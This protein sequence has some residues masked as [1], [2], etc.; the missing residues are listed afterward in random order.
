MDLTNKKDVLIIGFLLAVT[1]FFYELSEIN[2]AEINK[3]LEEKI[4][5]KLEKRD[6]LIEN[7]DEK[8]NSIIENEK[9][10]S[11][12]LQRILEK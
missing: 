8:L 6:L 9:E 7:L 2:S 11:R 3:N 5:L 10:Q 12:I 1:L 4:N